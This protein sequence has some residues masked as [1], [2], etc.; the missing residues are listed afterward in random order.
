[1]ASGRSRY[2]C[3]LARQKATIF[4]HL[5]PKGDSNDQPGGLRGANGLAP[6]ARL[7]FFSGRG[8]RFRAALHLHPKPNRTK[9][10]ESHWTGPRKVRL[11]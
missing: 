10:H 9:E 11:Q 2:R 7:F 8:R 4:T 3:W 5:F 1:M 6:L